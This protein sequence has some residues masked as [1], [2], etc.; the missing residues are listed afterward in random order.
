MFATV[1][2]SDCPFYSLKKQQ[3]Y[4]VLHTLDSTE[5]YTKPSRSRR[6]E[7]VRKDRNKAKY[8]AHNIVFALIYSNL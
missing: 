2:R 3:G 7:Q 8:N 5:P 1:G 4:S 6:K